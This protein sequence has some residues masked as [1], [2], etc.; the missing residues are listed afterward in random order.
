MHIPT[1]PFFAL[2]ALDPHAHDLWEHMNLRG[3]FE[4][5]PWG[6][7]YQCL[8]EALS[9]ITKNNQC[10]VT[11][12]YGGR[13]R[14]HLTRR[15]VRKAMNLPDSD[16][17]IFFKIRHDYTNN[18]LCTDQEKLTCN[19]LKKQSIYLA[20]QL[21][22]QHFHMPYPHTYTMP[23]KILATEYTLREVYGAGVKHDYASY[24]LYE[25]KKGRKSFE[26]MRKSKALW[27]PSLYMEGVTRIVYFAM[28]KI[29]ELPPAIE[30]PKTIRE[31]Q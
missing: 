9:P 22:T 21:H 14:M 25:I 30:V 6:P 5:P 15:S 11:N 8:W 26:S 13:E 31:R 27:K 28:N 10:V 16:D 7:D 19:D 1:I 20:L 2:H 29:D 18:A 12:L 4:L 23:K 3:F 17:I 24:L